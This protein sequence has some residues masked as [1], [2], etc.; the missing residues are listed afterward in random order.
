MKK[1][2]LLSVLLAGALTIT[3]VLPSLAVSAEEESVGTAETTLVASYNFDDGTLNNSVTEGDAA[4]A[5]TTGLS[6]YTG[7]VEYADGREEGSKAVKLGN[8][9][10][11]LNHKNLGDNFT[12]SLWLKPEGTIANNQSVLFLGYNN[13]EK[14]YAIAGRAAN[15]VVKMWANGKGY[16]WNEFGTLALGNDWHSVVI[17]GDASNIT[18]YFD[19][20]AVSTTATNSPLNGTNQDI[21]LGV[22]YWD[23]EFTGLM[24]DVKVY[25]GTMT[26][27]EIQ[28]ENKDYYESVLQAKVDEVKAEDLLGLNDSADAVAFDLSLPEKIAGGSVTWTSSNADVIA[29]DG[30]VKNPK[31]DTKVTMTANVTSGILTAQKSFEFTVKAIDRESIDALIAKAESLDT[32]KYT[33]ESVA[34]LNAAIDA[35]KAANSNAAIDAAVQNLHRA[36]SAL[37]YKEEY[38]DPFTAIDAVAPSTRIIMKT[39]TS[40]QLFTLPDSVKDNVTVEYFSSD[41]KSA[42]YADGKATALKEG[43]VTVTA[44]V[45]AKAT[46][47]K[48]EY[49][50]ALE[51]A[52]N[53]YE[54]AEATD[55]PLTIRESEINQLLT[56]DLALPT[57]IDG[58]DADITYSVEDSKYV[59]VEGSTL[60]VTRPYA[61]EGN[62][63]FT[64]TATIKTAEGTVTQEFPLTIAEGTSADTYAGYVYVSFGNVGGSDVQQL[65]MFLSEDGLNWTAL[66]GFNPI[67]EVGTDYADMIQS[68]GTHNYT[69]KDG[70]DITETVSGDASVL[71]PFEGDDQG[72][73][74]P[75]VLRGCREE[76]KDKVWILATDL[77]TMSSQYGGNL[78]NNVVGNWGTMSSKG[79]TSIFVYETED[80]VHWER[81]YIDVGAEIG[82]GA[83][84]APEAVYNP[85]KDNYLVYWSC[86]VAAD[87]YA[88]NRLYCNETKDFKTFGPTKMYEEEA[89]YEKWGKLVNANDGYGNIDT[90]QLWVASSGGYPYGTLYRL[91]KD[92]TNNHI[93]LMKANT[94]LDPDIDYDNS[95]PIRITPYTKDDKEYAALSDLS[96]LN[97]FQK[98][99]IVWNWFAGE[100]TG[101]HFEYISQKNMEAKNGAYEGAT[102]FKFNDRDE[103][104]I[105]IDYYGN[106][107]VRYEPYT[108]TDLSE[109]DSITKVTSGYGR[110]GGDVGCH[111]GMMPITAEEYNTLIDTYNADTSVDNYHHIDYI[112]CD[113]RELEDSIDIIKKALEDET[114][115]DDVKA[116]LQDNLTRAESMLEVPTV[117]SNACAELT[118]ALDAAEIT[119][120]D[121]AVALEAGDSK[122]VTATIDPAGAE[123][124]WNSADSK[125]ATVE[126]GTIKAVGEGSTFV[127]VRAGRTALA[128]IKVTV[129]GNAVSVSDIFVDVNKGDW[130]ENYVQYVYDNGIMTGLNSTHFG[131]NQPLARAQFAVILYR[132]NNTPEVEYK[133]TF[134]DVPDGQWFT[135]AILWAADT[136]VVTGYTDS[137]MFGPADNINR[138][139]IAVMMYRYANYKGY[140]TSKKEDFS[141]YKD[142]S[143]VSEFAK[144]AMQW[145]V[146]NKIISGKDNGAAL[147]PQGKANRAEC[148]TIIQRFLE[149]YE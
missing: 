135:D 80:W 99:E 15:N 104:C 68:A 46:G 55:G 19:G 57:Q 116:Q 125:V 13:P 123:L 54:A 10:L 60:K 8:Y 29:A 65:H 143:S 89:F 137:G 44:I 81:R 5:I 59:S 92:E 97:D 95:D 88:R 148:A 127:F 121:E 85:E 18:T 75:Y 28:T 30:T 72:I 141:G 56:E 113:K 100:S 38:A 11:Q 34:T 120:S 6:N 133:E 17:T 16:A 41:E 112:E 23:P 27:E 35:A 105:M 14:W 66:N 114:L 102:M 144:E 62:Y 3:S 117:D 25:S 107:S 115:S 76:D 126:N 84:W 63:S 36:I 20:V 83:A 132:L 4:V 26:E 50:T 128:K 47:Y 94:V 21:Y 111:G 64:L 22:T 138:E 90:S 82:A 42:T 93:E 136:K 103:W 48:E 74:D 139:Q 109:A 131:P 149:K 24:D 91:V 79:S 37:E 118:A 134:P 45:T 1:R 71:F 146:A 69:V 52:D 67:F 101:N 73:R 31:E 86:R 147:D 32:D 7:T 96:G 130:Y 87:G 43:K 40:E 2:R 98:A 49:S 51:I 39:G 119:V 129:A 77:N 140:D 53:V 70:A 110:T 145:A 33:E 9:G 61:G 12:V 108:T 124:T 142:A 122:E 106:N 58:A 78:N